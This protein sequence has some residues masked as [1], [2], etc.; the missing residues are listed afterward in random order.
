MQLKDSYHPYAATTILCWSMAFVFT[1]LGLQ[2]FTVFSLGVLRYIVATAA[3]I[4]VAF[5]THM[6]PPKRKDLPWF[7]LSGLI[8]FALY[9]VVFN[10]ASQSVT[11]STG[12]VIMAT[13]PILTALL[14]RVFYHEKLSG[15]QYTAIGVSFIGVLVLMALRGGLALS[16]GMP[17]M[18]LAAS[19]VA[20]YNLVQRRLTKTYSALQS[21]AIS[22][23]LGTA[24]L[25]VFLPGAI[26][27]LRTAPPVQYLYILI[28]GIF[29]SAVAYVAWSKALSLAKNTSSVSNYMFITPFLTTLLGLW[30]GGEPVELSTV[31]GGLLIIAGLLLFRFGDRLF[32]G[33]ASK[34]TQ[35]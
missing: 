11:S 2:F 6:K 34:R 19:M 10:L 28:L 27:Q 8:G 22:I 12:S 16:A 15:L 18:F 13:T 21:T 3:L 23:F 31:L 30:I 9:M 5:A 4:V 17:L 7:L 1:R 20:A 29:S 35:A 33:K 32:A 25:C 24:M 14:A 26:D